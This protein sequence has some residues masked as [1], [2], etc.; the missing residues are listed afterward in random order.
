F[1]WRSVRDTIERLLF[2]HPPDAVLGYWAHPDGEAAIRAARLA[3]VPGIIMV[4]GSDF[5][6]LARGGRR[7]ER[8]L[9][10]LHAADAVVAVSQ[11]LKGKLLESGIAADKVHV[12]SR[13]VDSMLFS[14]GNRTQARARLGV[15]DDKPML[16]WVGRMV[17]VK[18][19]DILLDACEVLAQRETVFR[20]YL[21]GDGPLREPLMAETVKRNL[22]QHVRFVGARSH[23]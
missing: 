16:L 22:T 5:L 7:R 3:H 20:F 19:L 13:G 18:G 21:V 9:D 11:D 4:G 23:A 1:L 17:T 15:S 12:V 10:V 2:A 6:L 14:P 8:I